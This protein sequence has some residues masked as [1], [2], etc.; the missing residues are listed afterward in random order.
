MHWK[1]KVDRNVIERLR[2]FSS[3]PI[4]VGMVM[5]MIMILIGK[6]LPSQRIEIKDFAGKDDNMSSRM[7]SSSSGTKILKKCKSNI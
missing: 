6:R 7:S 3:P 4:L 5:E 1:G 2:A